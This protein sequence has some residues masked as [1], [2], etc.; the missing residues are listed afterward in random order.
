[1]LVNSLKKVILDQ[2]L[3]FKDDA[4]LKAFEKASIEFD[5]LVKSGIA[6]KRGYNLMT[7]DGKHLQKFSC[8]SNLSR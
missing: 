2:S 6:K 4:T 5:K 1:M 3:K 7:I 8:N